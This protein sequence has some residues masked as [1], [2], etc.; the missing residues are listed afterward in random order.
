MGKVFTKLF[1]DDDIL[2]E[3]SVLHSIQHLSLADNSIAVQTS[4]NA[5]RNLLITD[6]LRFTFP[7]T[8][9]LCMLKSNWALIALWRFKFIC[10]KD[11][12]YRFRG[13]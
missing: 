2:G 1:W 4:E 8:D 10:S 12:V 5:S 7:L 11:F 3:A 6:L 9:G 13:S